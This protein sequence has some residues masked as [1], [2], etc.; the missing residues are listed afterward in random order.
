[1]AEFGEGPAVVLV[2]SEH[3]LVLAVELPP[4]A[5]AAR[6]RAAL[7]YALEEHIADPLDEVHV[8]LGAEAAP[9]VW[10]A[11]VVRHDLMRQW[12][13]RLAEA[14]LERAS[15]V[16][17][18]LSLP[19]PG[20]GT[21]AVD[22]AAER[23]MVRAPDG[24]GFALPLNLLKRAWAAAGEPTCIAYGD[25]LPPPLQAAQT[26][27]D[28]QP[29]ANRPLFPAIDLR[30]GPYAIPPRRIDPLWRRVAAVAALGA[31]AHAAIAGAD[32]LALYNIA[33]DRDSEVRAVAAAVQP[34][35]VIGSDLAT[36]LADMPPAGGTGG[37]SQLLPLLS[38]TGAAL[39]GLQGAVSWRSM[40]FDQA[41]ATLRIEVETN[42]IGGLQQI[43]ELLARAGLSAQQGGAS[44][45]LGRAVGQFAIRA[46]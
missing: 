23:A 28:V 35:L 7:P 9:G 4:M 29:P 24:T 10:L 42:D 44:V 41:T 27:L 8:A 18:A 40:S 46:T 19:V 30:Q 31:L 3:V 22:L 16:P 26:D 6:R 11:A 25:P 14:G 13:L 45:D 43:A 36:T 21:W 5:N 38:R 15:I 20:P 34:S 12:L 1:M 37:P 17:D 2:R 33:Q 39:A 32:T